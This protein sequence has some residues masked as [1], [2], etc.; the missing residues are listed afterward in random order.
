PTPPAFPTPATHADAWTRPP[1]VR[2]LPD[3]FTVLGYASGRRLF[4]V[5]GV[6][7]PDPLPV[8]PSPQAAFDA[9]TIAADPNTGWMVD[10]SAAERVG[11]GVRI[12]LPAGTRLERLVVLGVKTALNGAA[13]GV[14][15][16]DLLDAHRLTDGL[17][18][19]SQGTPTNNTPDT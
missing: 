11:M 6:Q 18:F 9:T 13:G 14:R 2:T 5:N 10:F 17:A 16:H 15:L 1:R 4:A 19:V 8:G 7:I 3:R 12:G